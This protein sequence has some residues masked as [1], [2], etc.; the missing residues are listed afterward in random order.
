MRV[1]LASFLLSSHV[2]TQTFFMSLSSFCF[3]SYPF[4]F[5][6]FSFSTY[7]HLLM[8]SILAPLFYLSLSYHLF[9]STTFLFMLT[10]PQ[11]YAHT[12]VPAKSV[13]IPE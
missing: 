1:S 2:P 5:P 6:F 9:S 10:F 3:L 4:H 8:F 11:T 7:L 13:G 12:H